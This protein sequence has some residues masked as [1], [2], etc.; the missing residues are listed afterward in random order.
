MVV[1]GTLYGCF[2]FL[3]THTSRRRYERCYHYCPK[4]IY[5]CERTNA[6]R[7]SGAVA[8]A[9]HAE[10]IFQRTEWW[11]S[12]KQF[13]TRFPLT[14][15][16]ISISGKPRFTVE[17]ASSLVL[18]GVVTSQGLCRLNGDAN[19]CQNIVNSLVE[20]ACSVSRGNQPLWE[21]GLRLAQQDSDYR[22]RTLD[23]RA[24]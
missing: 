20:K 13:G 16:I 6:Q 8:E 5:V 24:I 22:L 23:L 2:I 14:Y 12:P 19:I 17:K 3:K 18:F 9:H 15:W 4:N 10:C 11:W 7:W 21:V 1:K